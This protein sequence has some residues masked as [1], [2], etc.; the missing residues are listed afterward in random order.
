MVEDERLRLD[1]ALVSLAAVEDSAAALSDRVDDSEARLD[2]QDATLVS[3]QE[4][5]TAH[6]TR[7]IGAELE[8]S[9]LVSDLSSIRDDFEA[10]DDVF[11]SD[12]LA[13]QSSD[14]TLSASIEDSVSGLPALSDRIA[15][16]EETDPV[17]STR[18][19]AIDAAIT[20]MEANIGDNRSSLESV[21]SRT[22]SSESEIAV[23][24]EQTTRS[25]ELLAYVSVDDDG[26][27]IFSGTNLLIQN[28]SEAS[29]LANAKGNL[30]IGYNSAGSE[31]LERTGSTM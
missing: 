26:D 2:T 9:D 11:A 27:V 7:F 29:D 18:L 5:D 12:I 8:R 1:D 19:D 4:T 30:I 16:I 17:Q 10:A 31:I 6:D 25:D 22:S 15:A 20:D 23:L 13:L 3:L 14:T 24:Q 28:G 21:T